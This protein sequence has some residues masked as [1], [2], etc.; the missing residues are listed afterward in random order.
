MHSGCQFPGS[1]K[2]HLVLEGRGKQFQVKPRPP[3][4]MTLHHIPSLK[5][6]KFSKLLEGWTTPIKKC[7]FIVFEIKL[8]DWFDWKVSWLNIW[9][10]KKNA[11]IAP[12]KF[13]TLITPMLWYLK[14]FISI[15]NIFL[16]SNSAMQWTKNMAFNIYL[17][18]SKEFWSNDSCKKN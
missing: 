2:N 10:R 17:D 13:T 5:I 6:T 3:Y 11:Q 16:A 1:S 18:A 9:S 8:F 7:S 14:K 4:S 12:N 15:F